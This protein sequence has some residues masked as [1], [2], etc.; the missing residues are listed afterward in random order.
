MEMIPGSPF[1]KTNPKIDDIPF[2]YSHASLLGPARGRLGLGRTGMHGTGMRQE[3]RARPASCRPIPEILRGP[4]RLQLNT[5]YA[6]YWEKKE[7]KNGL[8][9]AED[10]RGGHYLVT[11]HGGPAKERGW[12]TLTPKII[13]SSWHIIHLHQLSIRN[14]VYSLSHCTAILNK[15]SCCCQGPILLKK[16]ATEIMT[17]TLTQ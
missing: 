4:W 3:P 6:L 7:K 2:P 13:L 15:V 10:T 1:G 5:R 14:C 17:Y 12:E 11:L 16:K 9:H 8:L